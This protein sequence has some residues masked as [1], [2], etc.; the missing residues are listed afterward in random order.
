[1]IYMRWLRLLLSG[2]AFAILAQSGTA[3]AQI[4]LE[5]LTPVGDAVSVTTSAGS[6]FVNIG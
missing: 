6:Y 3:Y 1:M 5:I 4:D 2:L